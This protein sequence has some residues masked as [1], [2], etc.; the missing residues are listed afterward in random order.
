MSIFYYGHSPPHKK[1]SFFK[2]DKL[3]SLRVFSK[4]MSP[5]H[6]GTNTVVH[7]IMHQFYADKVQYITNNLLALFQSIN[8]P[9]TNLYTKK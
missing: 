3:V 5:I 6:P 2:C 9:W 8:M 7:F 4:K 1:I